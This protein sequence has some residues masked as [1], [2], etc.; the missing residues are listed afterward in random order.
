MT[1]IVQKPGMLST[2]QDLGRAGWQRYGVSVGGA[3]DEG[4]LR[5][6]NAL[7]GNDA[8]A[9]AIEMTVVGAT[10][11][12]EK[13]IIAAVCGSDMNATVDGRPLPMNRPVL[14]SADSIVTFGPASEGCR[15]VV[16]AAGGIELPELLGSRSAA[17]RSGFPGLLGRPL[18]PGD[19]L[20]TKPVSPDRQR[21]IE[22]SWVCT[23]RMRYP[24]WFVRGDWSGTGASRDA[25]S[26][27]SIRVVPG[28]E[29]DR[30]RPD[31]LGSFLGATFNV[32]A[33]SDRMGLRL[34]GVRLQT[35]EPVSMLSD[36][37]TMGTVQVPA[38]GLPIVLMA[39]RQT[40]GGYPRI[41]QVA[42]VDLPKLAQARPGDS[43]RF[44]AVTAEE[45]ESLLLERE[46]QFERMLA[47]LNR[48]RL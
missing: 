23:G 10:L 9:A 7:V 45:A 35:A 39:D 41:G 42:R 16:A 44:I 12:T 33:Q 15:T 5:L 22:L 47:G 40:T 2:I 3:M 14:I 28:P 11:Q 26:E 48:K 30:F 4:A 46:R 19:K 31:S 34:S 21:A 37:V 32:T 29:W 17:L 18:R 8:G 6:A 20:E 43:L 38:D 27:H 24:S 36:A 25:R 1:F 13:D